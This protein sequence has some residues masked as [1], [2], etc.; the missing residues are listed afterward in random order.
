MAVHP[1]PAKLIK[2]V[3]AGMPN[4]LA[5]VVRKAV[6]EESDM[7]VLAELGATELLTPE[8][9]ALVDVVVTASATSDLPSRYQEMLF[10]PMPVPVVAVSVDGKRINVYSRQ[11]TRGGG[12][13]GLTRSIRDAVSRSRPRVGGM[14]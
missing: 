3:I 4:L 10:G 7:A 2:V 14:P 13:E 11:V 9:R 8:S 5:A 1:D 6:N 12:I